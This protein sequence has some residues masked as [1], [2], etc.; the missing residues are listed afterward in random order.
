MAINKPSLLSGRVPVT[1]YGNLSA[2]RNQ[3]LGLDQAEPNLGAG[4]AN[5]VLTLGAGNVRVWA[6]ALNI[7]S[8]SVT[9][10]VTGNYILGNGALL[11]GVSASSSNINNGT[12]NVT[13]V[14]SGGNVTVG[15]GGTGNIAVFA[16]TGEYVT[17]LISATGN[18]TGGNIVTGGL[19][20]TA[21][22][23]GT[24]T[25]TVTTGT[26]DINLWPTAGNIHLANTY[27]NHVATP[28]QAGDAVNKQYV[29]D[30]VAA[31][32][33]IHEPVYVET[34]TA[35]AATYTQG[36]TTHTVTTITGNTT[37]TFSST[38]SLNVNDQI[39][40]GSTFNG[41][42]ANTSYFVYS[43]PTNTQIT[44]TG[45]PSGPQ[46]TTL[47][48]GTGLSQVGRANPGV[49][50][51]LTANTNGAV[52]IDGVTLT[53]T[54][55]VLV[56]QQANG[57]QNGVYTVTNTGNISAPWIFTRSTDADL[58]DPNNPNGLGA[59]DYF[60]VQAGTIGAGQS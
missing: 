60:F 39:Y 49:G 57:V 17:G 20:N 44:L 51:T 23:N 18:I 4:T 15:V 19:V 16:N 1:G 8:V 53:A 5:S 22:I 12:S 14:S 33:H 3:F 42:T 32:I 35:L 9:G 48:N 25:L 56:Y 47:T 24:T 21:S 10:N 52:V 34:T 38:H 45:T 41:I 50:A 27:I 58:Y 11:T 2:D 36:G 31:G 13:V 6:N 28:I 46:I 29:D 55:R 37:L 30:A 26:G 7:V 54:Q 40:W 43:V 59:G